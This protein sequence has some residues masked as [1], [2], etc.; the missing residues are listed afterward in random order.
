[1]NLSLG[2][3]VVIS[4]LLVAT[5]VCAV[6]LNRKLSVLRGAKEDLARLAETFAESTGKAERGLV[7]LREVAEGVGAALQRRIDQARGSSDDLAFLIG[8]ASGTAD[9]LEQGVGTARRASTAAGPEQE[10]PT[11]EMTANGV[12][13]AAA[14]KQTPPEH[15]ALFEALQAMR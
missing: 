8:K 1:M 10:G 4:L 12:E 9:R 5:I 7:D 6:V 13:K 11:A 2:F 14:D 15:R 3:D